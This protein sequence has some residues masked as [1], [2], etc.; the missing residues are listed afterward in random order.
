MIQAREPRR[1]MD[2][3]M[4]GQQFHI[5]FFSLC[6]SGTSSVSSDDLPSEYF[7]YRVNA[8]VCDMRGPSRFFF[9][10]VAIRNMPCLP[11][12]IAEASIVHVHCHGHDRGA[13]NVLEGENPTLRMD[14]FSS[15]MHMLSMSVRCM[16]AW[17]VSLYH[18]EGIGETRV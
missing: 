17:R 16:F 11:R 5:R 1:W 12:L 15:L 6:L 3:W 9:G 7:M 14:F 2:G 18:Q 13:G 4:A 10:F 8:T